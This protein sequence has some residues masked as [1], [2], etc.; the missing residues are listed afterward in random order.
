MAETERLKVH[1]VQGENRVQAVVRGRIEVPE[2]KP[3]V[4]KVLSK[5]A[6]ARVRDISI[7]PDKVIVNGALDVQV[8]Y[9]AFKPDQS[10]NFFHD[11]VGITV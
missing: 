11:S 8:T 2:A 7:V 5:E 1:L 6:K 9:V 3:D 10:V 4:D